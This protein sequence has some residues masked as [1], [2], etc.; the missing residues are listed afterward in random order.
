M[1]CTT[2]T[3]QSTGP[4]GLIA[5]LPKSRFETNHVTP[6]GIIDQHQ[7]PPR[8]ARHAS[9][10][11]LSVLGGLLALA[12]TGSLGGGKNP[13]VT[14]TG[15]AVAVDLN[16]PSVIRNGQ[17]FETR[18]AITALR[19]M[20]EVVIAVEPSL[21]RD[22]TVNSMIPAASEERFKGGLYQF[23]YGELGQGERLF[24][25]VDSQ[26]NP[27]LFGGTSGQLIVLDKDTVVARIP[28]SIRVLP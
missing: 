28:L 7:V 14:M 17:F 2:S 8:Y 6:D 10:F 24:V 19:P 15:D 25:K 5:G 27:A 3:L 21:W 13:T 18:I 9:I 26:I 16:M 20:S 22:F 12:A 11:S 23:S 4:Q 1:T